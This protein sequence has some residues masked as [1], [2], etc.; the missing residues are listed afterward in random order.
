MSAIGSVGGFGGLLANVSSGAR[1]VGTGSRAGFGP[2]SIVDIGAASARTVSSILTT[3]FFGKAL[4]PPAAIRQRENERRR[5]LI[6]AQ[7]ALLSKDYSQVREVAGRMLGRDLNDAAAV[8][9]IAR[10]HQAEGN[11]K[12]ATKFFA[13]AAQLAPNNAR[14]ASDFRSSQIL[15]RSDAAVLRAAIGL[16]AKPQSRVEGFR[17][18]SALADRSDD[19][20]VLLAMGD[21]LFDLRAKQQAVGAFA[22]A[23]DKAEGIGLSA[24]LKRADRVV[25][26]SPSAAI[27]HNFRGQVL[28]KMERFDEAITE[29]KLARDLE[30]IQTAY[31]LDLANAFVARGK[32][33]VADGDL[34]G[35]KSDF[36]EARA[37]RP[38]NDDINRNV[39]DVRIR[40]A[41]Q[42]LVRGAL[43]SA[44]GEL[45][46]ARV[47]LPSDSDDLKKRLAGLYYSLGN[48]F[49]SQD[50]NITAASTLQQAYDLDASLTHKTAL[51][52]ARNT[53]GLQYLDEEN[54]SKA[55]DEFQKAVDL[56]PNIQEYQDNLDQAKALLDPP[57]E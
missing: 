25:A 8:H 3:K 1:A 46:S 51:G 44:L 26:D 54:Y 52:A 20:G 45:N 36:L 22:L 31:L 34:L 32:S 43:T 9:L 53:L 56:F 21:A 41:R 6:A 24:V 48:R 42:W 17:L 55:V 27:A 28:Q 23:L 16:L 5:D 50:D 30:P 57:S 18:L 12:Q 13:R 38:V 10:S 29:F 35:G 4:L 40:L 47:R 39:A 14:F 15:E 19:V 37:I 33:R 11:P 7:T 49:T 2:A